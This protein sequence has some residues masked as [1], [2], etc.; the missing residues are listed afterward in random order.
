M[1]DVVNQRLLKLTLA[2][3]KLNGLSPFVFTCKKGI[4]SA[5]TPK[6]LLIY[7]IAVSIV[8]NM[9]IICSSVH[10]T[11]K[12][13]Q[14]F[15]NDRTVIFIIAFE[16]LLCVI[17]VLLL[18]TLHNFSRAEIAVLITQTMKM[19]EIIYK[20]TE[21]ATTVRLNGRV[22]KIIKIK[23]LSVFLQILASLFTLGSL[24]IFDWIFFSYPQT[25]AMLCSA[26]YV[27][28][29]ML[30]SLNSIM[31]INSKLNIIDTDTR[32]NAKKSTH[33]SRITNDIDEV[34][35]F[36]NKINELLITHNGLYGVHFTLTLVGS[37]ALILCSVKFKKKDLWKKKTFMSVMDER[38]Y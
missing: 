32:F 36:F 18:F 6:K 38:L 21:S 23:V 35:V 13:Y 7:S 25:L 28:S 30:L 33:V 11:Y 8:L 4:L 2:L 26:I 20:F 27:F 31:C 15:K 17:K 16:Y 19:N 9:L 37:S 3:L 12:Y 1:L 14:I 22:K 5:R 29:F 24:K 34:T 10:G